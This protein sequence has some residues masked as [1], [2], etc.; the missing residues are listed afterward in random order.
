M[1]GHESGLAKTFTDS[2]GWFC[3]RACRPGH[4]VRVQTTSL[5]TEFQ[6]EVFPDFVTR[7]AE[8]ECLGSEAH[9]VVTGITTTSR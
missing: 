6:V 5:F 7:L 2:E 3:S 1:G 9:A 8:Q 4:T